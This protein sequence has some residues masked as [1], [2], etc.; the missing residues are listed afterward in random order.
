MRRLLFFLMASSLIFIACKSESQSD[1]DVLKSGKIRV[2]I[3]S[4]AN[5]ELD[6]QHA[7]AYTLFNGQIFD[8]E[9][10]TVNRTYHGGDIE[11][12]YAEANRIV[13]LCGLKSQ[14]KIYRG[15]SGKYEEIKDHINQPEFDGY[16]A[17]QF[18]IEKAKADD[19][20]KLVLIPVGKLTNIALALKKDPS[21][22]SNVR[23][24]WLGSNYPDPGEYNWENDTTA[25]KPILESGVEFEMVM[26][27]YGKPTGTDA[28][29]AYLA[30]IRNK[31]PGRGPHIS[32]PVIGRHGGE[33]TNF[34]DYSVSLFNNFG[35]EN[36]SRPLFDMAA[37]AIVKNPSWADRVEIA[38][39][40][41]SGGTWIDQPENP[42]KIVIW[43]NFD[44]EK[45]MQDFYQVMDKYILVTNK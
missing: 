19:D 42:G 6:D 44:K 31:M 9:G 26:V 37:V 21:I 34:G 2:L 12:H 39:P 45:I 43:E 17:V 24:V 27:R 22:V 11:E 20:R 10:I 29:K 30:D 32:E 3:D 1:A 5:N 7:I 16:E 28:I 33:F 23:V 36:S 25:L 4:D 15:A 41:W 14:I 35:E 40:K 8:V 13:T 38:A 18:I